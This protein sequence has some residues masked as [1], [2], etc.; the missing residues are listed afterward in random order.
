MAIDVYC[1]CGARF[2]V[3]DE[4]AGKNGRCP[5]CRLELI[6]PEIGVQVTP[7]A[8]S[9]Q[10]AIPVVDLDSEHLPSKPSPRKLTRKR[11]AI[12][13][14]GV[15]AA[16]LIAWGVLRPPFGT[17]AAPQEPPLLTT[18]E[19]VRKAEGS[20]CLVSTP[21]GSGT[22]FAIS[23]NLIATNAHVIR[24]DRPDSIRVAFQGSIDG[25]K[26]AAAVEVV[27]Y[28]ERR[29]LA[30]LSADAR[31]KPLDIAPPG[32]FRRGLDILVIGNP[33]VGKGGVTLR[34][35]VSRG[36]IGTQ[37][38]HAEEQPIPSMLATTSANVF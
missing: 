6:V 7:E 20:V 12:I 36:V 3:K 21:T 8:K 26:E 31:L 22:G 4:A 13:A 29:D 25:G 5:K 2:R 9:P 17:P 24:G 30:I 32:P 11:G 27:W 16:S 38:E 37:S 15:V 14:G 34:N 23:P 35:A 33:A 10:I 28:D 1:R 19:V 18:E